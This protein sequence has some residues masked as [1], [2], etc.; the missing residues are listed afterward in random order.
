MQSGILGHCGETVDL[1]DSVFVKSHFGIGYMNYG[2]NEDCTIHF[3]TLTG[4]KMLVKFV[5]FELEEAINGV[6]N[7][8]VTLSDTADNSTLCVNGTLQNS[9][10]AGVAC[11]STLFG[12]GTGDNTTELQQNRTTLC[13]T[14]TGEFF[15][16]ETN[17]TTIVFVTNG[18][19]EAYGFNLL[20][21]IFHEEP[22][23]D[24]EFL[25]DTTSCISKALTCDGVKH[26][27]DQ[28]DENKK[29]AGC[30][31]IG[32]FGIFGETSILAI[33]II[34]S[35]LILTIFISIMV[36]QI[37][38]HNKVGVQTLKSDD[39]SHNQANNEPNEEALERAEHDKKNV[40]PRDHAVEISNRKGQANSRDLKRKDYNSEDNLKGQA[41]EKDGYQ[42]REDQIN[43]QALERAKSQKTVRFP[44][45][46]DL[47][48]S[49]YNI[50]KGPPKNQSVERVE[51]NT[52]KGPS[53]DQAVERVEYNSIK[54]PPKDQ[55]RAEDYQKESPSN[56]QTYERSDGK[57]KKPSVGRADY[58]RNVQYEPKNRPKMSTSVTERPPNV[59]NVSTTKNQKQRSMPPVEETNTKSRPRP[60]RSVSRQ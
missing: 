20:I 24:E 12:N 3:E 50:S 35:S 13:G 6:C 5:K 31:I 19:V 49:E 26:C 23:T 11:N 27:L 53:K 1:K 59:D 25:C 45:D 48:P 57:T 60:Q 52:R 58:N 34:A 32:I 33:V 28:S 8:Y 43:D 14:R 47:E 2:I 41:L 18:A 55:T 4:Y 37:V 42:N 46:Q 22:C 10:N 39:E 38:K 44:K 16:S 7:D 30:S 9:I 36:W 15:V 29:K 21:S 54:G 17:M 40:P 51:Y 56:D